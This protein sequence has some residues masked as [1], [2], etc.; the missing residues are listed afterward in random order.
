MKYKWSFGMTFYC[1][2]LGLILEML[3]INSNIGYAII[4]GSFGIFFLGMNVYKNFLYW[5]LSR[6]NANF[7]GFNPEDLRED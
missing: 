6:I 5:S 7:F 1:A 3:M 4:P 2:A